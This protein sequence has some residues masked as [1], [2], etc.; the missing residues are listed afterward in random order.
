MASIYGELVCT[1]ATPKKTA[2]AQLTTMPLY[3]MYKSTHDNTQMAVDKT[4]WLA[5]AVQ[6]QGQCRI[7]LVL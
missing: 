5:Q 4:D 1:V 2:Y 6:W 7:V 3:I